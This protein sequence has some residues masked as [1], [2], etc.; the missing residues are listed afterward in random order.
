M[1][2]LLAIRKELQSDKTIQYLQDNIPSAGEKEGLKIAKRFVKMCYAVISQ[3]PLLQECTPASIIKAAGVSASLD[4]DI[5]P[6]GL[7][8]LVPYKNNKNKT[9][10]AQLQIGYLGLIE[11][12]FRSGKVKA[13]SAHCVYESE[14]EKVKITRID[15]QFNVVH[16]FSYEKTTGKVIAVYAS[17]EIEGLGKAVTMV[18]RI[19]EVEK[20]RKLSKAPNSP[21]WANHYEAMCKKTAIRQLAKFLPKSILEDFSRGAAMDEHQDFAEEHLSAQEMIENEMGTKKVDSKE[22]D[23]KEVEGKDLDD[24]PEATEEKLTPAQRK[25]AKKKAEAAE[26]KKA[27]AEK[28]FLDEE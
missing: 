20:Y 9:V 22:V 4:L 27:D 2:N 6:R 17:A 11:L 25:A 12:A 5:D 23:S 1:S 24:D 10:E 26:K 15:G 28:R 19:D 21:A 18:L 13:I 8:Y 3:N 16:P 7:A 14:K